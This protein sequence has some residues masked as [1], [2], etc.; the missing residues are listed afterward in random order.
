[1]TDEERKAERA[2][3]IKEKMM[4]MPLNDVTLEVQRGT[5]SLKD[6]LNHIDSKLKEKQNGKKL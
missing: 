6:L 5:I 4:R 1:M 2:R 3:R